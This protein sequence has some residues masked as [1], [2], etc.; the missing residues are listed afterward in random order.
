MSHI[1]RE[2]NRRVDTATARTSPIRDPPWKLESRV[3]HQLTDAVAAPRRGGIAG[4]K[5]AATV[6]GADS[7]SQSVSTLPGGRD[8]TARF[9]GIR[10]NRDR[11]LD[12][13]KSMDEKG[14]RDS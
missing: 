2:S 3:R 9:P 14:F 6:P 11:A 13:W 10:P 1:C 12:G 5:G 8:T 4:P 7:L